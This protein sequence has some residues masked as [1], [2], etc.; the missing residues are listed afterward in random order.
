M[1]RLSLLLVFALCLPLSARADDAS[2]RAKTQELLTAMH[3]QDMVKRLTD[4]LKKQVTDLAQKEIARNPTPENSAKAADFEKKVFDLVDAQ[5]G[6]KA[7]EPDFVDLYAKAF[8]DDQLDAITAF[9]K[10]P[11]GI[12]FLEKMA[13]I[14]AQI[15]QLTQARISSLQP[16]LTPLLADFRG[17]LSAPPAPNT[18]PAPPAATP[19]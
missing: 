4:N 19:K 2:H 5:V 12:A 13:G 7:M 1:N 15:P 14:N 8:T 11:A 17:S 6:W 3:T 10:S 9:Y 16:Q 18:N